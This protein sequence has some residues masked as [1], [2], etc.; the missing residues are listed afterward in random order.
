MRSGSNGNFWWTLP[1]AFPVTL[2]A[3]ACPTIDRMTATITSTEHR[4]D[5]AAAPGAG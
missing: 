5:R 3:S 2:I 4:A 1:V